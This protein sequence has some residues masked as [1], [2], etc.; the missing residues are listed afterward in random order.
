MATPLLT[1]V[2]LLYGGGTNLTQTNF[3]QYYNGSEIV[4]AGE[5]TDNDILTLQPRVI[6]ISVRLHPPS[7]Q[8][9]IENAFSR[10]EDCIGCIVLL[11]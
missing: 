4:V 5:I 8:A 7:C 1:D 11:L 6:A 2:A 3:S 10:S 9:P